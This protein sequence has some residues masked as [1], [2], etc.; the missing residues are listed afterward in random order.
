MNEQDDTILL[1]AMKHAT[2]LGMESAYSL[3]KRHGWLWGFLWGFV[4]AVFSVGV[5]LF[6]NGMR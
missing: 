1:N 3:G 6:C 5:L 4:F 2:K